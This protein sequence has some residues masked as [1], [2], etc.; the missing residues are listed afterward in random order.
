MLRA[1]NMALAK[2]GNA[3]AIFHIVNYKEAVKY[4]KKEKNL[5]LEEPKQPLPI[6]STIKKPVE[7]PTAT[8]TATLYAPSSPPPT[9]RL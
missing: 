3:N 2:R 9:L 8:A 4:E 1:S 5:P 7:G 6:H